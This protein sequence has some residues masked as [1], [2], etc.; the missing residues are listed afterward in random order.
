M[1][2]ADNLFV[3]QLLQK[4]RAKRLGAQ[5]GDFVR[6]YLLD[7]YVYNAVMP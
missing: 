6:I 5:E 7:I 1:Y 2:L 3:F 4:D